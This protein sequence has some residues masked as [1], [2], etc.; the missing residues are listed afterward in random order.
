MDGL[1][2]MLRAAAND[3]R[4]RAA[5]LAAAAPVSGRQGEA[6]VGTGPGVN[7]SVTGVNDSVNEVGVEC[8]VERR[9]L[10]V[11]RRCGKLAACAGCVAAGRL[12]VSGRALMP[13]R[14]ARLVKQRRL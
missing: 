14:A 12:Q 7:E 10:S 8:T 6:G 4:R 13:P 1:A 11:C 3:A 2:A 9:L 5:A